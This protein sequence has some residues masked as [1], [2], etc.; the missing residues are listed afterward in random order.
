MSAAGA[1][2]FLGLGI[3]LAKVMDFVSRKAND[4]RAQP[5]TCPALADLNLWAEQANGL[6]LQASYNFV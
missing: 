4:V 2:G 6:A 5:Y 1:L 3:D